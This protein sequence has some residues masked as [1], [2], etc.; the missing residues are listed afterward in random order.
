MR[1]RVGA[2]PADGSQLS[3]TIPRTV[4][5]PALITVSFAGVVSPNLTRSVTSRWSCSCRGDPANARSMVASSRTNTTQA[6]SASGSSKRTIGTTPSARRAT[7]QPDSAIEY[8]LDRNLNLLQH[9][10]QDA[11]GGDPLQLRFRPQ[12]DAVS[13]D[14]QGHRLHVIGGD[15]VKSAQPGPRLGS[16]E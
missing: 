12:L 8:P 5:L 13:P 3:R 11:V 15:G 4:R 10:S 6:T 7:N 2:A 1:A 14:R 9:G 16:P